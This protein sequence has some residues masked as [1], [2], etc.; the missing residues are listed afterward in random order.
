MYFVWSVVVD[1]I[2]S[3]ALEMPIVG[4]G[5]GGGRSRNGQ[6]RRFDENG[7]EV[8]DWETRC[9]SSWEIVFLLYLSGSLLSLRER[10][11]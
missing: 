8:E 1:I 4:G 11:T 7:R 2:V 6:G 3:S 9:K 5:R 10:K